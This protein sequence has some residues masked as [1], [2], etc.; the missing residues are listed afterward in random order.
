MIV[1]R[2]L[3]A[4]YRRVYTWFWAIMLLLLAGLCLSYEVFGNYMLDSDR[5]SMWEVAGMAAPRWFLFVMGLMFVTVNLPVVVAHGITRR[6]YFQGAVLF[7]LASSAFASLFV[8][9]GF[10]VERA[11]YHLSGMWAELTH[12]YPVNSLGEAG[13]LWV[14]V[15]IGT[16][17]YMVSGWLA[18]MAFYRLRPW[19]AIACTPVAAAPLIAVSARPLGQPAAWELMLTAAVSVVG[20]AIG[21]VLVRGVALRPRKA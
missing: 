4:A 11:V 14:E 7:S 20:L 9:F 2:H 5:A 10:G 16:M 21:Y 19:I 8:L 1:F 13:R 18:G 17:A 12:P 6:T 15:F 3:F